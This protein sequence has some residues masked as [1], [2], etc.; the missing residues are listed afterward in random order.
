MTELLIRR[1]VKNAQDT[2]NQQVRG[3]YGTLGSVVGICVNLLLAAIKF[4]IGILT[5]SVAV[6]ADAA[7]NLSDAAGSIVSLFS[8][9]LAQKPVDPDHPYGHGRMEY[10]G[11][12]GVGILILYMGIELLKSS[13]GSILHP[14]PTVFAWI[15]FIILLISILLKGWLYLFYKKVGKKI[16]SSTLLAAASDSV[17]DVMATGAVA[18]SMLVAHLTGWLIDGWMG[19]IVA[20]LV[21]KAGFEVLKET[22]DSLLGGKPDQELGKK[23]IDLMMQHEQILGT[24]D[25]MIHDYGPGRCVASI[26]A[27]VPADGDILA[28][29]EVIDRAELEI[30]NEL[31]IPICIHMDP[32]VRGD[33]ET[34][35]AKAAIAEYLTTLDPGLMLHDFRRVPGE[36]QINLVF[37]VLVQAGRKDTEELTKKI[38]AFACSLDPRHHCVIRYDIDYYRK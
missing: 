25:L 23:I 10:I 18:L 19:L 30:A 21:L 15:P 13:I 37:D 4:L 12:L 11:A 9:R 14:E 26:H 2:E 27:E 33:A 35:R 5:A 22:V 1:F 36:K 20:L 6:T 29:H 16:D 28:L 31:H 38:Q 32:I 34:D 3:A 8:V 17:S 24:H 7:N